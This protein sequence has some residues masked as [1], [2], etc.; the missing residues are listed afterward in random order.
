MRK[1]LE[2]FLNGHIVWLFGSIFMAFILCFISKD[3]PNNIA[4]GWFVAV[5]GTS[6]AVILQA[7]YHKEYDTDMYDWFHVGMASIVFIFAGIIRCFV[8]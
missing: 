3:M 6:T 5:F 7:W 1:F 4:A 2:G 8:E